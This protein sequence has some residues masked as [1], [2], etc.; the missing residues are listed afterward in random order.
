MY[1][2]VCVCVCVC[3]MATQCWM[4]NRAENAAIIIL[5]KHFVFTLNAQAFKNA[6]KWN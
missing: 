6:C 4:D 5:C 3:V 2:C 1:V